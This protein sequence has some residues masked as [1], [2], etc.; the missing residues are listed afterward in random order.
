MRLD[1]EIESNIYNN[2]FTFTKHFCTQYLTIDRRMNDCTHRRDARLNQF[3]S[4]YPTKQRKTTRK[5][6][7]H[8]PSKY[9]KK[10]KTAAAIERVGSK[11]KLTALHVNRTASTELTTFVYRFFVFLCFFLLVFGY[12]PTRRWS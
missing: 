4:I 6:H 7:T 3:A 1:N 9:L 8:V 2:T 11:P 12:F 10:K 5:M